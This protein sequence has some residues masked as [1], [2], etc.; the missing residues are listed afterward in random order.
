MAQINFNA[1]NVAPELPRDPVPAGVYLVHVTESDVVATKAGNGQML[2]LTH[3]ILD[4]P[5][6]GRKV[7]GNINVQNANPEAER[8]GQSQLSALCHAVNVLDLRDTSMLHMIPLRMR[9]T[10][11]PAGPDKA[12]VP[13]DAQN[14]VKGYEAAGGASPST[15]AQRPAAPAFSAPQQPAQMPAAAVPPAARPAADGAA[16]WARRA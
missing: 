10:I 11:R 2:K 15:A 9:V 8:I 12:G 1:R 14:E 7:F 6:K 3:E 5:C 16:P 13:R 4:G